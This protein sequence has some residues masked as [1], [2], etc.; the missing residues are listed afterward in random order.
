LMQSN[1]ALACGGA[2]ERIWKRPSLRNSQVS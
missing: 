2:I 1:Y